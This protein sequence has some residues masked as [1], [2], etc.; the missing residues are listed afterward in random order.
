MFY[1]HCRMELAT[2]E[3][4]CFDCAAIKRI[5][6]IGDNTLT[7]REVCGSYFHCSFKVVVH[8]LKT[9][10]DISS[11]E[12]TLKR[13]LQKCNLRKNIKTDDSVLRKIIRS[14]L[15]TPSQ[16]LEYREIDMYWENHRACRCL[17][18]ELCNLMVVKAMHA[19]Q[20]CKVSGINPR[21]AKNWTLKWSSTH[22]RCP[23]YIETKSWCGQIWNICCKLAYWKFLVTFR[24]TFTGWLVNFFQTYSWRRAF[25]AGKL[26]S[27]G[28]YKS[29]KMLKM[30]KFNCYYSCSVILMGKKP[31][32]NAIDPNW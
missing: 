30:K 10:C 25:S 12:R 20:G 27:Y 26:L 1:F 9:Y 18:T 17:G 14:E 11:S 28:A 29:W 4:F 24:P 22:G 8:F 2:E 32:L 3:C 5:T 23:L 15:E 31:L 6:S 13:R 16:F 21:D 19:C 7:E